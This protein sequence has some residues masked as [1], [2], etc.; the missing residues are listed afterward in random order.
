[1]FPFLSCCGAVILHHP[2]EPEAGVRMCMCA[3]RGGGGC[4]KCL[5]GE[6]IVLE[7]FSRLQ[8]MPCVWR[9]L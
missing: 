2:A 1:M 7:V 5:A 4:C 6:H 3:G 9:F 8:C